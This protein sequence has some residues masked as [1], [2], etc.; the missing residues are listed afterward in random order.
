MAEGHSTRRVQGARG[1]GT[2]EGGGVL[3]AHG[4]GGSHKKQGL[5][6]PLRAAFP[7]G[8]EFWP[9][10][11]FEMHVKH[12]G[13]DVRQV[14]GCMSLESGRENGLGVEIWESYM[15]LNHRNLKKNLC[16][17]VSG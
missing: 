4:E 16:K 14:A 8:V 15:L 9:G 7:D 17:H 5:E 1:S 6:G 12:P 11:K 3:R 10:C 2:G 13:R